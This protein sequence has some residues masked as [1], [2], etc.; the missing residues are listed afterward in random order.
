ML[1][2]LFHLGRSKQLTIF[3]SPIVD[4]DSLCSTK[5]ARLCLSYNVRRVDWY[6]IVNIE[7]AWIEEIRGIIRNLLTD[8]S[9]ILVVFSEAR[10][11]L[12]AS[13]ETFVAILDGCWNHRSTRS[14]QLVSV[15]NTPNIIFVQ[16]IIFYFAETLRNLGTKNEWKWARTRK[17]KKI[18][19]LS[20]KYIWQK[21]LFVLIGNED[22]FFVKVF[23]KSYRKYWK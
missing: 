12:L 13:E 10:W 14:D 9:D 3:L 23:S 11:R 4:A 8:V 22:G 20:V 6:P 5:L 2:N 15:L 1:D 7:H 18:C 21:T 17:E 19:F 16:T